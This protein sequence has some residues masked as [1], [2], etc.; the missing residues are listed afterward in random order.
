MENLD[1]LHVFNLLSVL[2]EI[3]REL[4]RHSCYFIIHINFYVINVFCR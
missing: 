2:H 3:F 1:F 4:L